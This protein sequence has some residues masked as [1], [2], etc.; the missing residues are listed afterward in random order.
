MD[1]VNQNHQKSHNS[2]YIV[3]MQYIIWNHSKI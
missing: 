1:Y 3:Y 2:V